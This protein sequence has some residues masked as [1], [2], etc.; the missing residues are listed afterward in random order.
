MGSTGAKTRQFVC[1]MFV[2][3]RYP[4][5]L[6]RPGI[7][8]PNCCRV[9]VCNHLIT[10][11]LDAQYL[12]GTLLHHPEHVRYSGAMNGV[13]DSQIQRSRPA[14]SPSSATT[15]NIARQ[16][17]AKP[18]GS[19]D[20]PRTGGHLTSA[21][22]MDEPNSSGSNTYEINARPP[23]RAIRTQPARRGS[24]PCQATLPITKWN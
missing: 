9:S 18:N 1:W 6:W 22:R 11:V 20:R 4:P 19:R 3:Q 13:R 17:N 5:S 24:Q 12:V 23:Q 2:E 16:L 7:C 8:R 14:G 10:P 21:C 15:W